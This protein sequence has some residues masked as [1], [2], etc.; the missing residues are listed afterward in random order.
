M[1]SSEA[2]WERLRRAQELGQKRGFSL[3]EVALAWVLHQRF[4]VFPLI[5]PATADELRSSVRALELELSPED[6]AWLD[7]K[8]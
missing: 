4:P 8:G 1:F 5:G 7:L 6:V 3:I 2:N